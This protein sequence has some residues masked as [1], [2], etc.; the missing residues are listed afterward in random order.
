MHGRVAVLHGA[1]GSES[2]RTAIEHVVGDISG[3][4]GVESHVQV[5]L[6]RGDTR[7]SKGAAHPQASEARTRLLGAA[8]SAGI[9]SEETERA[10]RGVLVTLADRV[11]QG[12]WEDVLAH[13]PSD[14]KVMITPPRRIGGAVRTPA[15]FGMAVAH[16]AGLPGAEAGE[17]VARAVL[18][19]VRELVPEEG[20]DVAAALPKPLKQLWEQ[21]T[22]GRQTG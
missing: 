5:G 4:R 10:V 2:D 9:R 12:E 19:V 17:R 21:S 3:V 11:P 18:A 1:V 8:A 6:T 15:E 14:V 20:S 16:V 22:A 13:L 7:P